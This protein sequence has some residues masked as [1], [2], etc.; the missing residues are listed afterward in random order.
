MR[1]PL[2]SFGRVDAAVGTDDH[3]VGL[4]GAEL[5][6]AAGDRGELEAA[7]HGV[8]QIRRRGRSEIELLADR[9]RQQRQD[10]KAGQRNIEAVALEDALVLG[11]PQRQPGR[12]RHI[13]G[14]D[15]GLLLSMGDRRRRGQRQNGNRR[16]GDRY[17]EAS[18][19]MRHP[20]PEHVLPPQFSPSD[21][22]DRRIIGACDELTNGAQ[23]SRML[24]R[25]ISRHTTHRPRSKL[26]GLPLPVWGEGWGEGVTE[27][28]K[29]RMEAAA[30][31][32]RGTAVS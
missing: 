12:H 9:R 29:V 18:N 19:S 24:C 13:G 7:G 5:D 11:D 22:D 2:R 6:R 10:R 27:L 3:L 23:L 31:R 32:V 14:A 17:D 30:K 28:S 1:L 25:R 4:I 20:K 15:L 26:G 8:E 21:C 16:R